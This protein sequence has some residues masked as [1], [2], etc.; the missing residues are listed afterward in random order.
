MAQS[1]N[2]PDEI[3]KNGQNESPA[4]ESAPIPSYAARLQDLNSQKESLQQQRVGIMNAYQQRI[5]ENGNAY[6][7]AIDMM[8]PQ[9][10]EQ[11]EKNLARS[12]KIV[13]LGNLLSALA[14]GVI[15]LTSKGYVPK[16]TNDFPSR[17]IA[18][19][20]ELDKEYAANNRIFQNLQLQ[21]LGRQ[22]ADDGRLY[23]MM[24]KDADLQ[25]R[26]IDKNIAA[27]E[28]L[29][30]AEDAAKAKHKNDLERD[31]LKAKDKQAELD[32]RGAQ[33]LAGQKEATKRA[34]GVASMRSKSSGSSS[35]RSGSGEDLTF[36]LDDGRMITPTTAQV[37]ELYDLGTKLGV[38]PKTYTTTSKSSGG[39]SGDKKNAEYTKPLE[40]NK[41]ST[42]ARSAYLKKAYEAQVLLNNGVPEAR[43]KEYMQN[44]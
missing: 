43:V 11:E 9:W 4:E 15:G 2:N 22:A 19:L 37:N 6:K 33:A 24:L 42:S 39:F 23:G 29:Q 36:T 41:L 5:A 35:S 20:N 17:A 34:Y 28:K 3:F 7:A 40:F 44:R 32:K 31:R 13:A 1:T 8:R 21:T 14:T 12:G 38:I 18:R 10:K 25:A 26:D 16:T 27:S 30:A